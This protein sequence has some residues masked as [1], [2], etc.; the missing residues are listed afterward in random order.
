MRKILA[1]FVL[2]CILVSASYSFGNSYVMHTAKNGDSYW[3]IANQYGVELSKLQNL[4]QF[5]GD[6]LYEGKLVKVKPSNK[7][8]NLKVNGKLISPDQF[9]Y[10]ENNRVYVPI[11]IISEALNVDMI[12]WDKT[13]KTAVIQKNGQTISLPLW[14]DT[15]QIDGQY[16]KLD[17][18]INVYNGRTFVPVRFLCK[19]FDI[20]VNWDSKNYTVQI[21]TKSTY[22]EI[23]NSDDLYWL[24]RIIHAEAGGEP[25][26]GKV[27]VGNVI[28]NR[29]KSSEFPN[30]IKE[31]VFDK[32]G[33]YY[34]FSPVLNGS[35]NNTPSQE[36][37]NAAKKVLEGYDNVGDCLYFLNPSKSTNNWITKN[38]T[39]YKIIGLHHFYI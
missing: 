22:N 23:T 20:D 30:T 36:S 26:E 24:S 10:M 18:P 12:S 1:V 2:V 37:I 9:P 13:N 11:R 6:M 32:E 35:I 21:D 39:F 31:V 17:A 34:Q 28:L 25:F 8:I 14:S 27:A 33:G 5:Y 29:K 4:N 19:A 38:K 3:K 15:A 16:I 7:T